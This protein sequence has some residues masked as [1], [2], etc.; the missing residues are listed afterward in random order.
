MSSD[1]RTSGTL[2]LDGQSISVLGCGWLGAPL[3]QALSDCGAQLRVASRSRSRLEGPAQHGHRV[4]PID[5][6]SQCAHL[7]EFLCA[8][9]LIINITLKDPEAY[10]PLIN[11]IERSTIDRLLFVSSTSVYP[12]LDRVVTE[13]DAMSAAAHPLRRIETRLS[14]IPGVSTSI[15]RLAG[16]IGPDRHPGRFFAGGRTVKHPDT[17]VNLIHRQDA[18]GLI[19]ALISQ[20]LWGQTFNGCAPSHPTR[21][22]FYTQAAEQIGAPAP[23]CASGSTE[24]PFKQIDGS[25]I[26]D[27]TGYQF[28]HPELMAID[29]ADEPAA[30]APG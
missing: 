22:A 18:L 2:S 6:P 9:T 23:R 14:R 8:Q 29:L 24:D 12:M 26:T 20:G 28:L 1:S 15:L 10:Q 25:A 27:Q 3:V 16:L 5:L 19:I 7:D 13:A 21:R 11:A 17:P 30:R 4:Y